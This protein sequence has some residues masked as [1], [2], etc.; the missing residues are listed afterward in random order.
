MS[1]RIVG[2]GKESQFRGFTGK[3]RCDC[4]ILTGSW[5]EALSGTTIFELLPAWPKGRAQQLRR[6]PQCIL[7]ESL[8]S[9]RSI[10]FGLE[11]AFIPRVGNRGTLEVQ[12]CPTVF[13]AKSQER[14]GEGLEEKVW[15]LQKKHL[16]R[17]RGRRF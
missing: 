6:T 5:A 15:A 3:T 2:L 9:E 12:G 10:A 17:V 11:S 1:F 8:Y 7:W 13:L 16:V 4:W 14:E